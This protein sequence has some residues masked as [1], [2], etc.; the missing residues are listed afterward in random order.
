MWG[1]FTMWVEVQAKLGSHQNYYSVSLEE[2]TDWLF[3][4][5]HSREEAQFSFFV[6]LILAV[7]FYFEYFF[8]KSHVLWITLK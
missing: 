2:I 7:P 8:L 4:H 5:E 1:L 3:Y 6:N